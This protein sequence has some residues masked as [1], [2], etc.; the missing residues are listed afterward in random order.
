[1]AAGSGGRDSRTIAIYDIKLLT[2][3]GIKNIHAIHSKVNQQKLV[4]V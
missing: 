4:S 2:A 1:V 3:D